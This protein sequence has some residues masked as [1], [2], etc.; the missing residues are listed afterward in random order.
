M[1]GK[2]LVQLVKTLNLLSAP[3]GVTRKEIADTLDISDRS[4]SR[5]IH[6]VED[7]GIP[8]YDDRR[9]EKK[10]NDGI[11]NPPI[12]NACPTSACRTCR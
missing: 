2:N 1:R 9:P 4:V 6:V 5:V 7:L 8:V 3:R 11:L 12:S 10:R